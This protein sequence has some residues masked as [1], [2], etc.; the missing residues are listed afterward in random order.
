[1]S[2]HK[3]Y[4]YGFSKAH[5]ETS[6]NSK[7]RES[8]AKT[9]VAVIKDFIGPNAKNISILDVGCSTGIIDYYLSNHFNSVTGIDIDL[10]AIEFAKKECRFLNLLQTL[11]S[12]RISYQNISILFI[13]L[14]PSKSTC[15]NGFHLIFS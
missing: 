2:N 10:S 1:M 3:N 5:N 11:F 7:S 9:M 6:Y 13:D 12:P 8:K 14:R 4:Q 15:Y